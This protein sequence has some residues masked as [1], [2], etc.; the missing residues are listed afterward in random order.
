MDFFLDTGP[1]YG[2]SNPLSCH[3]KQC[4]AHFSKYKFEDHNYYAVIRLLQTEVRNIHRRRTSN[5]QEKEIRD[6]ERKIS[7]LIKLLNNVDYEEYHPSFKT[8]F[9]DFYHFLETNKADENIKERDA[10]ILTNAFLWDKSNSVLNKPKFLT[11]DETDISDNRTK[12]KG[13]AN[14]RLEYE[15][16]MGIFTIKE[17]VEMGL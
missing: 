11:V 3:N 2:F 5:D 7:R 15:A 10:K 16:K 14:S 12:L 8:L 4:N 9:E 17:M 13:I 6:I 1:I